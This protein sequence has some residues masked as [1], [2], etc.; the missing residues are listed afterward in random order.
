MPVHEI[1]AVIV[2]MAVA[3]FLTRAIVFMIFANRETPSWMLYLSKV[4][5]YAIMGFLIVYCLRS[6][7]LTVWPHGLPE[8]IS[9][10][11]VV[12]LHVYKKNTLISIGVGTALYMLLLHVF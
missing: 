6:V 8:T 4:L 12:L 2:I 1:L 5:P 10:T 7:S 3:T 9:L 11:A